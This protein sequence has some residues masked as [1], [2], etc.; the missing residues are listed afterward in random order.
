MP[1]LM[2]T[3]NPVLNEKRFEGSRGQ[4]CERMTLQG[5]VNKTGLLLV[6]AIASAAWTWHLF[7]QDRSPLAVMPYLWIG[8][9]GG[10]ICALVTVFKEGMVPRDGARLRAAGRSGVR[11]HFGYFRASLPW[12]RDS[13]GQPDFRC[14]A[15]FIARVSLRADT[16][17]SEFPVGHC[18]R[19]RSNH[20]V[21]CI[22]ICVGFFRGSLYFHQRF[23]AYR[24][25]HQPD[26]RG[27]GRA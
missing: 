2:R 19:D 26:H 4:L 6:C 1:Q 5:T 13:I 10:F 23:R 17:D 15:R 18:R 22:A 25:W 27:R 11:R 20:A 9:I 8:T 3:S 24:H 21:L 14:L 12:H 7:M 16:R